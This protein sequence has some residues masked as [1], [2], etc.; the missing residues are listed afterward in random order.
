MKKGQAG[1][2][3]PAE[4]EFRVAVLRLFQRFPEH[5][6]FGADHPKSIA[7]FGEGEELADHREGFATPGAA[8]VIGGVDS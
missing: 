2:L 5:G 6:A 7:G 8:A 4:G 3:P 1:S